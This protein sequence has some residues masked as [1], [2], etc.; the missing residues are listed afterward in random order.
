[1]RT[2]FLMGVVV[3]LLTL[4][5]SSHGWGA[6]FPSGKD[7]VR[8]QAFSGVDIYGSAMTAINGIGYSCTG[9]L[10][11]PD[12]LKV[13]QYGTSGDILLWASHGALSANM[14]ETQGGV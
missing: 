14:S 5:W 11:N 1:M 2:K 9:D 6:S 13:Q 12:L 8:I 7:Y 4:S 3:C 10:T